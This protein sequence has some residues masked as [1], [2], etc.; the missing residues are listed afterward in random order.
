MNE[1]ELKS[2][3]ARVTASVVTEVNKAEVDRGLSITKLRDH[4]KDLGSGNLDQAWTI[5]YSTT[6]IVGKGSVDPGIA[7][8]TIS[9]ATS[10]VIGKDSLDTGIK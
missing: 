8:W 5:S 3:V 7:A 2:L 6:Q 10:K 9:Y 4:A 1:E